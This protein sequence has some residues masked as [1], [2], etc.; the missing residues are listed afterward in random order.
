MEDW[1][2]D[3]EFD[4]VE[5]FSLK[6]IIPTFQFSLQAIPHGFVDPK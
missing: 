5:S 1:G 4:L 6:P 2:K 3:K